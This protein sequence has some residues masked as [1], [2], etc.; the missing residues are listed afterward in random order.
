MGAFSTQLGAWAAT[1][2]VAAIVTGCATTHGM[3]AAPWRY[4]GVSMQQFAAPGGYVHDEATAFIEFCVELDSQDDRNQHPDRPEYRAQVDPAKWELVYDSRQ[5]VATDYIAFK[6]RGAPTGPPPADQPEDLGHWARLYAEIDKTAARRGIAIHS[7]ADLQQNPDLNGFG[8]WQN[9]WLLYRGVGANAGQYAVAIRGT[10]FSNA[11]SGIEDA[12]LQPLVGHH[13]LSK[14]VSYAQNEAAELHGGFAHATFTLMLD[15]RY[16]VLPVLSKQKVP[17]SSELFITGHSQGAAMATMA[18]AFLFNSMV[19]AETTSGD[20]LALRGARYR[21]KSYAIAQPKPG[22]DAFAAEFSRFTQAADNAIVINNHIDPVPK[23]PLTRETL[24]DLD[25]DFHGHFLLAR[26]LHALSW[27]ARA[28]REASSRLFDS[29]TRDSAKK[30]G[31]FY[32]YDSLRPLGDVGA[33][34]SWNFVPAGRVIMVYGAPA[35][36]Q[37]KDVFFQHHS[38]T[39]RDLIRAQLAASTDSDHGP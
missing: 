27:P 39:Y 21:L 18:H 17:P 9:A 24:A 13:F 1:M 20:P 25:T 10:V 11:P 12:L 37:G 23:V 5:A 34:S 8:P 3:S 33:G 28:F 6:A 36:D 31:N 22:N 14:N 29:A 2:A 26:V 16:G 19:Q 15:L 35:P 7:A 30:Y 32:Q 4:E 38:T